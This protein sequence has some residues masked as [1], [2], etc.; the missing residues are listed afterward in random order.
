MALKASS[1]TRNTPRISV[2]RPN[3]RQKSAPRHIHRVRSG[4]R[5]HY[6]G[7]LVALVAPCT[8]PLSAHQSNSHP[9]VHKP[10]HRPRRSVSTPT[11]ALQN[12]IPPALPYLIRH[13]N[14]LNAPTE[15]F[16]NV[17]HHIILCFRLLALLRCT[18]QLVL[19]IPLS[20]LVYCFGVGSR[21][22]LV[23]E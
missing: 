12:L 6:T 10:S 16:R 13:H 3:N 5:L 23:N 18:R 22:L 8:Q 21:P 11:T 19:L 14:V 1:H 20:W 7:F 17:C 9:P 4:A 2:H 15:Q